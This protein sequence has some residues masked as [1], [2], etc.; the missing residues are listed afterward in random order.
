MMVIDTVN[1]ILWG[2]NIL[3]VLLIGTGL[4][5]TLKTEFIQLRLIKEMVGLLVEK[6]QKS[7]KGLTSFEAFCIS[8][9]SRV[10]AGNL[11]GVVAAI[12]IGGAG[13]LFWMWIVS[14]IG[15]A[16]ALAETVLAITYREDT[17]E[18][19]L[20]GGP[21]F[22]LSKGLGKRWLGVLFVI[23]A[24]ICW[25][26]VMQVVSNS[27]TESFNVAF[28]ID[29]KSMSILLVILTGITV[30]SKRDRITP[31]LSKMVPVMA[32]VYLGLVMLIVIK[33][34]NLIPGLLISIVT[35]AFGIKEAVGGSIGAVVMNGVK[36]G[37]FS[38]EAG[39]G[40]APCVA[41]AAD[42][43][44]PVKQGL[45]QSLGVFVDTIFICT[46]T[47][48]VMLLADV[49]KN[50]SGMEFLQEAFRFHVGDWG[51][52]FIAIILFLFSFSTVLGVMVYAK[53]NIIFLT[54]D[55]RVMGAFKLAVLVMLFSGGIKQNLFVWSLADFGM[56]LMTVINLIGVI[57]LSGEVLESVADYED[58]LTKV[59]GG[60]FLQEKN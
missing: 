24:L 47:A 9:A 7:E 45:I 38:N 20:V 40:S 57:K 34:I 33:N 55:K 27:V 48:F 2:K 25:M 3:V 36:R 12:S 39:S 4:F 26:G 28:G 51:V 11:V 56:G 22:V 43:D 19:R 53:N 41:A 54:E 29:K 13:A 59:K 31:L 42:V 44:H 14:I 49:E 50:L 18:G 35:E 60:S 46:A 8:T 23:S 10:G 30:F 52:A 17:G 58:R 6:N 15:A 16:S 37:L 1:E 32:V 5:F 21:A